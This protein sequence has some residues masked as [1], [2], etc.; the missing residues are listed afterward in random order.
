MLAIVCRWIGA[1]ADERGVVRGPFGRASLSTSVVINTPFVHG[2]G[3]TGYHIPWVM[4][5]QWIADRSSSTSWAHF[6]PRS[7]LDGV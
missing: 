5:W 6:D 3:L 1:I 4:H 2:L 7:A